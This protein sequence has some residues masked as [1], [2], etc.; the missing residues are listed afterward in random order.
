VDKLL[1]GAK[2]AD[3]PVEAGS[4]LEL[5][6]NQKAARALGISMPPSLIL[7]ADRIIG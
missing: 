5:V 1:R 3:V 4:V 7:R 2:P 6:V